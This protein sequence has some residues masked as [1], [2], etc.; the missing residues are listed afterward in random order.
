M[1]LSAP[2]VLVGGSA[3]NLIHTYFNTMRVAIDAATN[4]AYEHDSS[5][6]DQ[7]RHRE[8][9]AR[10]YFGDMNAA[11]PTFPASFRTGRLAVNSE[12]GYEKEAYVDDGTDVV[13][14]I[15]GRNWYAT[16]SGVLAPVNPNDAWSDYDTSLDLSVAM[17]D[18]TGLSHEAWGYHIDYSLNLRTDL[19]AG[20]WMAVR[21]WDNTNSNEIDGFAINVP[22]APY[23]IVLSRS[24]Y[25]E[26]AAKETITI[27]IQI[28]LPAGASAFERVIYGGTAVPAPT[29]TDWIR[30]KEVPIF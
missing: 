10:A 4:L 16:A 17:Q 19:V 27:K 26:H 11:P 15:S 24:L 7:I 21:L 13:T 8:G 6:A 1:S 30:I 14:W 20:G 9:S 29:P 22:T 3:G 25:Y 23:G 2:G 18:S 5:G 28:H 12:A